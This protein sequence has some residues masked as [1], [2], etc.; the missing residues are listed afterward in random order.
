MDYSD[1]TIAGHQRV[2]ILT[3]LDDHSRY[4]LRCQAFNS[5]TVTHVIEA[6]AYTAAIHGY[7]QST[8]IDNGRA[9]TTSN[10]RTNPAR[11]GF[12]QLL[13]D[14]GI[15]Q[16][17]GRPY[18]PQTQGKVERFHYTL[19]LALRNKPQARDID[20]LNEQLDDII[21]YY[22][23]KRPHRALNRCT[24]AEA[25]NALPKAH[26]RPGAKTHD[27][28]L[29]TDKVAKNGKTTLRWG[30]QLRRI[31]IGRRWTGEPITIM[32]VDN[33]A[34]I[35]ITATGQHIA[36]YTLTPDKI[37]YNQKD[38]ELNPNPGNKNKESSET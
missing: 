3:I 2:V 25:Y 37:Y 9:F 21:D 11:N 31:Y 13:L 15:E 18:H 16:K 23:N 10:D 22:N 24:P 36:H 29:R 4:V 17:N 34:D 32:C 38:N 5:A 19:K 33:T 20:N 7:P 28:R 27:Y 1:W 12:E 35:K 26:P 30:G 14:L 8:L 6:F